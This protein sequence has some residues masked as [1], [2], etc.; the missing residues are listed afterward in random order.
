LANKGTA[1][2]LV[3]Q[4]LGVAREQVVTIGD[5]Y[6]DLPMFA[7]GDISVAMANAPAAVKQ[8]ASLIAPSNDDEGVA[9]ALQKLQIV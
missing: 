7:C 9:W 6:N 2:N 3:M 8:Q 4:R 5:N 1:L